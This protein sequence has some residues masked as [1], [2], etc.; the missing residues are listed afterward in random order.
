MTFLELQPFIKM[1][2]DQSVFEW[3]EP[4]AHNCFLDDT[5]T[6]PQPLYWTVGRINLGFAKH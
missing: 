1:L 4:N 6:Y 3:S 5:I 2:N